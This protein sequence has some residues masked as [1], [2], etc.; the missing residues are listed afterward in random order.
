MLAKQKEK[1][2]I[3]TLSMLVGVPTKVAS[4]GV[5][6][7]L[8]KSDQMRVF[9]SSLTRPVAYAYHSPKTMLN[10]PAKVCRL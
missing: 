8:G 6:G 4:V 9:Q 5:F 10:A 7:D 3:R 2:E 1:T